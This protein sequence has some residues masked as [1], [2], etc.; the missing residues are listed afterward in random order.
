MNMNPI[1]SIRPIRH[2]FA[3]PRTKMVAHLPRM[4]LALLA[5]C[6]AFTARAVPA[7][8]PEYAAPSPDGTK[9]YVTAATSDSLLV[10]NTATDK[11][12]A[13]WILPCKP[14]G[15]AVAANGTV[16]IT[17]G[18][19]DGALHALSSEGK[20]IGRVAVG[21]TPLAPILDESGA[22][23]YVPNRFGG[24][25]VAVDTASMTVKGRCRAVREPHAVALGAR[26]R[27]LFVA[28]FLP[29]A[30]ADSLSVSAVVTLID[31]LTFETLRNV[32]LPNGST[33]LRGAAATP[34]GAFIYITHVLARHQ[35]PTTQLDRGWMNTAAVS[36]LDGR[37]GVY[38]NTVL[39]D[40]VDLGAA[41]PWGATVSPDGKL[42]II[43]HAG[44]QE[45]SIIDRAALHARLNQAARNESV[46]DVT[47]SSADVA[48]DL[49]FLTGIRRRI[50]LGGHGSRGVAVA[51]GRAYVPLYFE[52]AVA[53]VALDTAGTHPV[54]R[55]PLGI[56]TGQPTDPVR[57]GEMLFNDGTICFQQWQSCASCHPDGR[58][59]GLNWDLL[60]DGAGN[61]K[62]SKS[63]VYCH[64][65]PPTMITGIRPDMQACNRKGLTHIHFSVR[66]EADALCLDAYVSALQ[67]VPSPYRVD[68]ALSDQAKAGEIVF[69][70]AGC[71]MCH[72]PA[73]KGPQGEQLFTNL[74]K[75]DLG[76]GVGNEKGRAFDT[77][78][79]VESWRNAPY[80]YDGRALTIE[81]LFTTHNPNN[82]HSST[83]SLTLEE[84]KALAAFVLSF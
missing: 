59:D 54:R 25:V 4:L 16:Y 50:R 35:L 36:I 80:L 49:S 62:Q 30:R 22:T 63:L 1:L 52:D 70:K 76:L 32:P 61:P 2:S 69:Q 13:E 37:T 6:C 44:T 27:T 34:D 3:T 21:H 83:Q 48:N 39:L 7:L 20:P 40:E 38:I 46:N 42:L 74:K 19:V 26:G 82:T 71:V 79:L 78:T 29:L 28:N 5:A 47:R 81:E 33:G 67:P 60:N 43:A 23:V 18:G 10:F 11:L 41:N 77:P 68:G 24:D 75:Y 8:S 72:P 9:L 64:L 14:S 12:A 51:G 53:S 56:A 45:I 57:R 55:I 84:I 15:V 73:A 66:P 58:A 65:T 17:G 31:T